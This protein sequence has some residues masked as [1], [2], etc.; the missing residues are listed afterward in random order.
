MVETVKCS[1]GNIF[2]INRNKH[3]D[4]NFRICNRCKSKVPISNSL[5]NFKPNL[6]WFKEKLQHQEKLGIQS[7]EKERESEVHSSKV[8]DRMNKEYWDNVERKMFEREK[9][10]GM[11]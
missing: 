6:N 8:S 4:I 2:P 1:C 9:Q 11:S 3:K 5:I 7:V 10:K